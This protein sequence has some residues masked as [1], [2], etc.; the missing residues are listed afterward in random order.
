M[1]GCFRCSEP[2][3]SLTRKEQGTQP[4]IS[5]RHGKITE[6]TKEHIIGFCSKLDQYFDGIIDC[7]VV[8][9]KEKRGNKVEIVITVPQHTF[10]ATGKGDNLY[11]A[12][13]EAESKVEAQLK[14]HH[15][16]ILSHH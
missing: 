13:A 15:D 9:D 3:I 5:T 8:A 11:I 16:K 10:T 7:E 4:I 12:L 14:K 2:N 6:V 1:K